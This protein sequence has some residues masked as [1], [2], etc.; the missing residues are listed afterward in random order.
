[1]LIPLH[2]SLLDQIVAMDLSGFRESGADP[3]MGKTV[4]PL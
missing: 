4:R 2:L 1:M 3:E